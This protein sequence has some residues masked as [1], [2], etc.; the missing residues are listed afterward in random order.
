VD[1][2]S[3]RQEGVL[4]ARLITLEPDAPSDTIERLLP[5]LDRLAAWLGLGKAMVGATVR[6][7]GTASA[8]LWTVQRPAAKADHG[9]AG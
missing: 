6:A 5:E 1:L 2:K 9:E 3:D 8:S 7:S 4:L